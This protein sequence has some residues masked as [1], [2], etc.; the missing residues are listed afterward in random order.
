MVIEVLQTIG[1][2]CTIK[3][4]ID[5]WVGAP[6]VPMMVNLTKYKLAVEISRLKVR[7]DREASGNA[8]H[9]G[10]DI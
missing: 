5:V 6:A 3:F 9:A 10:Y 1:A 4:T 7:H 8:G 2:T